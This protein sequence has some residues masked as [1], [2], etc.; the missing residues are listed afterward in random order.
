[1]KGYYGCSDGSNK[2][3]IGYVDATV[4][5]Q[6]SIWNKKIIFVFIAGEDIFDKEHELKIFPW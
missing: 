2:V 5:Y 3:F 6:S 4:V 1:M